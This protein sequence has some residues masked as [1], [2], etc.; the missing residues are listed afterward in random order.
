VLAEDKMTNYTFHL[1][2]FNILR[3]DP[4]GQWTKWPTWQVPGGP[5]HPCVW[6]HITKKYIDEVL[7]NREN[8]RHYF[9]HLNLDCFF[10]AIIL[11]N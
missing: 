9:K 6:E 1:T 10:K 2:Y 8:R 7:V 5:V 11:H 4:P 3:G